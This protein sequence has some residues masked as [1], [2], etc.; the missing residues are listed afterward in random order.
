MSSKEFNRHHLLFPRRYYKTQNEK[1]LRQNRLLI[2]T[3]DISEHKD[4]HA[5][6]Q[7]PRKL[8]PDMILGSLGVLAEIEGEDLT[9]HQAV[10]AFS[11][12]LRA[13]TR[14]EQLVAAHLLKQLEFISE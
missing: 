3:S 10:I 6:L 2:L 5:I 13:R 4:L 12:Y 14:K 11:D 9:P 1:R 8:N 7:P